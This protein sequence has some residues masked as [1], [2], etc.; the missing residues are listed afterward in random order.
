MPALGVVSPGARRLSRYKHTSVQ[1]AANLAAKARTQDE[2]REEA[3][4]K[5]AATGV[6]RARGRPTPFL[7]AHKSGYAYFT[8]VRDPLE[9]FVAGFLEVKN[10]TSQGDLARA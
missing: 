6:L 1:W 8:F 7:A 2:E 10:T 5:A 3:R 4:I 9:T